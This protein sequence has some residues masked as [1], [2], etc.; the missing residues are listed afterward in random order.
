MANSKFGRA[1][2]ALGLVWLLCGGCV[3]TNARM[4][5]DSTCEEERL[6]EMPVKSGYVVP[7]NGLG[8]R[9]SELW[10]SGELAAF[11][12]EGNAIGSFEFGCVGTFVGARTV[13]TAAHCILNA[14]GGPTVQSLAFQVGTEILWPKSVMMPSA[15]QAGESGSDWA[16]LQF[17]ESACVK[18]GWKRMVGMDAN[19]GDGVTLQFSS[20]RE[21][22]VATTIAG[23]ITEVFWSHLR[24]S[25][26]TTFGM[27]GSPL[28]LS[29]DGN[30]IIAIHVRIDP[31]SGFGESLKLDSV[32]GPKLAGRQCET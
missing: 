32:V 19:V 17:E 29:E 31:G 30:E 26:A 10:D 12:R 1:F 25:L 11:S 27:S 23:E 13:L 24:T 22:E 21:P 16:L 15:A 20:P 4:S 2:L 8:P 3:G 6:I 5:R 18:C 7:E 14:R 28:S 9:T